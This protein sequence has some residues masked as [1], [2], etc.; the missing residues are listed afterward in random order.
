MFDRSRRGASCSS[1]DQPYANHNGGNVTFGPDGMLYIG[2]GDGGSGGDPERRR[3][4]T[5]TTLLG[6]I[7]RIDP[8]ADGDRPYTV[9]AD[10]PFVGVDGARPE[11]WSVG[12]RN[13]WRF[14]FDRAPATCGSATSA[15]ATCEEID[16]AW[17]DG[18]RRPWA[19]LRLE[20]VRGH[21]RF[22]DDQP[23]DGAIAAD[24]RVST[25]AT[26][27]ARSAAAR[28]P[29][30]RRSR[31]WSAGT[32]SATTAAAT[33]ARS[34]DVADEHVVG[35]V[36]SVEIVSGRARSRRGPDGELYVVSLNGAD[37]AVTAGLSAVPARAT[38]S[39]RDGALRRV[40]RARRTRT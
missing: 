33:C 14:T 16:V 12:L 29:R 8:D 20:R 27:A 30:R 21:D 5:S 4:R 38:R 32:C 19:Q 34:I 18:G 36:G 26:A 40:G 1:I 24:L 35:A 6:K 28:V 11:I 39:K 23:P 15:R 7:L 17:A 37:R 2:M 13:P 3:A 22:N 10:N 25:T 9:P 31:R